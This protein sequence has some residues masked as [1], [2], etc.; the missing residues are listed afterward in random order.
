MLR[1]LNKIVRSWS[2]ISKW[3]FMQ[4]KGVKKF[5]ACKNIYEPT[6]NRKFP[7]HVKNQSF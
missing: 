3:S 1:N 2:R 7:V 4:G 5:F 6:K